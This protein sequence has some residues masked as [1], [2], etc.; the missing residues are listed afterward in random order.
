V[1]VKLANG[2]TYVLTNAWT[3]AGST[4]DAHDGKTDVTFEGLACVEI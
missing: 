1:Q 4:I 3:V 2:R